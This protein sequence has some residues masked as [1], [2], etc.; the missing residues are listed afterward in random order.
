M[1]HPGK[2]GDIPRGRPLSPATPRLLDPAHASSPPSL[3]DRTKPTRGD[4]A[5]PVRLG[6]GY[7]SL[8]GK[9]RRRSLQ[10]AGAAHRDRDVSV[11]QCV[12]R[13]LPLSRVSIC[14]LRRRARASGAV[15]RTGLAV[16][17]SRVSARSLPITSRGVTSSEL[18]HCVT[19][20]HVTSATKPSSPVSRTT[21]SIGRAPGDARA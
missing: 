7:G 2:P 6:G 16:R 18:I 9:P 4:V 10:H 17:A 11:A 1:R 3:P 19:E 13:S 21:R 12:T 15:T 5:T 20:T 8:Q 14:A